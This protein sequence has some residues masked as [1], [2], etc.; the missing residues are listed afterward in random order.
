MMVGV[1]CTEYEIMRVRTE[2]DGTWRMV[3][4][5]LFIITVLRYAS[6]SRQKNGLSPF[7]PFLS[8]PGHLPQLPQGHGVIWSGHY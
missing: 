3:Y 8:G 6:T 2:E 5:V 7:F 4:G 1:S